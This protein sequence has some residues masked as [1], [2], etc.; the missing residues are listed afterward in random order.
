M[1]P[2]DQ[3]SPERCAIGDATCRLGDD[4]HNDVLAAA[5]GRRSPGRGAVL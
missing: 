3:I 5:L 4:G 2:Y 1:L